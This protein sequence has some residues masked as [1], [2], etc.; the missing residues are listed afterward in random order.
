M[1]TGRIRVGTAAWTDPSLIACGRFYPP[2]A[3]TPEDR[4]RFYASQFPL[5]EVNSSYYAMPSAAV[6]RRWAERTP[7]H[8]VFDVK[9]FRLFTGH[10]TS[11]D[12]L[13]PAVREAL[14][15]SLAGRRQLYYKDL[16]RALTDQLWGDFTEALAPLAAAGKLGAVL[17]QFA[18][19]VRATRRACEHLLECRRRIPD[20]ALSVEFRHRSWF[21]RDRHDAT[22]AFERAHRLVNVVVDEPQGFWNSVPAVWSATDPSLAVVR[23]HGRNAAAWNRPGLT[24][25]SDRFNYDYADHELAGLATHVRRL[26]DEVADVHVIFNNNHEDQGQRNARTLARMLRT[27]RA[28][29]DPIATGDPNDDRDPPPG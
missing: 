6:A 29:A 16:P 3:R 17:F 27:G 20:G 13:P 22:L 11:R 14:P 8:F 25:A 15:S 9:A 2:H 4:L 23:L 7:E 26:A 12:A 24:A 21:D 28:G 10:R 19:W 18:P 1:T 5:V